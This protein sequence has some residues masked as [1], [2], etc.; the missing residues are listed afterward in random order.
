MSPQPPSPP[1]T[2]LRDAIW[3]L[4]PYFRRAFLFGLI[5]G[6]LMLAP[7]LY[8]FEVYGRVLNSHSHQTLLM[9]TL[10]VLFAYLI[11]EGLE[12]ARSE[13]MREAGQQFD[14][15][16]AGRIYDV[17][18]QANLKRPSFSNLYTMGEYRGLRD[19]LHHPVLNALMDLPVAIIFL[20]LMFAIHPLLGW[21]AL[22]AGAL[23]A[24]LTWFNER[25]TYGPILEAN[26]YALE[27][28]QYADNSLRNTEVIEAIG[29]L[30]AIR[31]RWLKIQQQFLHK[32]AYA[33]ERAG[34]F[35]AGTKFIQTTMGSM[36][37]GLSAWLLLG[38]ALAGGAAMLMVPSILGGRL[39]G[40]LV[41]AVSQWR[42]VVNARD[43]WR[44]IHNL[45]QQSPPPAPAMSLPPP[46]GVLSVENLVAGAPGS[47]MPIL[48]GLSFGLRPGQ[49]LAVVGPSAAGKTTLARLLVGLWPALQ[50]KVR[51]DGADVQQWDKD[52]LGPHLGYLP[53]GVELLDGS[54]SDNIARFG[55]PEPAK[56][57]NAIELAGLEELVAS[58]PQGLQTP[59]GREGAMLSG[60]QRQR[61]AL[62]R[63]LYGEP[64][65]MVLDEPNA[66]LDEV[67]D[68]ALAQAL[69]TLKARGTAIVVITHRTSVLALADTM[70]V[71]RDGTQQAFGPRNEVMAALQQAAQTAA[72]TAVT[73][74]AP[75]TPRLAGKP[76]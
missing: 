49:L 38:D 29:M 22:A 25:L 13:T 24:G 20:V 69:Q 74:G 5:A 1:N 28:Q 17:I 31:A 32:Q 30:P 76:A 27:A 33:S 8:M 4:T 47:P 10:L 48:K 41:Q 12:W 70:L 71:L 19:F 57:R 26:R 36:F 37:L 59:I 58:L 2:E 9:L 42:S 72:Q 62:A 56:L 65:L 52:E 7:A 61:V 51:L 54:L 16:M 64:A 34:A 53:Q 66:S 45:L 50:G 15:R 39:L 40:P 44:R 67:G 73:Q 18:Y 35:Q 68:A 43:S 23:Q 55:A 11:M 75:A 6:L 14:R 3:A 60:G 21:V 46:K 63:A